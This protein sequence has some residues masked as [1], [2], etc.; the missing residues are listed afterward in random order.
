M[1]DMSGGFLSKAGDLCHQ[2]NNVIQ[3]PDSLLDLIQL[4][5]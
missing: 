3:G 1:S 5:I 2:L 4:Q